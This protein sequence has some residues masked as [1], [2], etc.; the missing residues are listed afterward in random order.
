MRYLIV[1]TSAFGDIIHA[2]SALEFLKQVDPDCQIDWVVEKRMSSLVK[3]HPHVTTCIELDTKK[4]R[5]NIRGSWGE[6]KQVRK[7]LQNEYYD[8]VFDL[9]GNIKS[10][11]VTFLARAEH[12]VG[13]GFKTAPESI[14]ACVYNK[15]YNPPKGQNVRSDYLFLLESYFG[16]KATTSSFTQLITND[17]I[18]QI[19]GNWLI[20]P[21][22]NWINKQ[23]TID[24]LVAFLELCKDAYKPNFV[25]LCGSEQE[26]I[27]A[28]NLVQKFPGS[29]ILYKPSLPTLQHIMSHM[30]LAITMDSLPLHLAAT[31]NLATF[32]FFGPS[33]SQKYNPLGVIHGTFQGPCHYGITFNKRCP[34]LRTCPTGACLRETNP[35]DLFTAFQ[36][37]FSESF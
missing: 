37:W 17:P 11:L 1:K 29:E 12:K 27:Q 10:G 14:S 9:Q 22:S 5:S 26:L 32:S 2:Y 24:T 33:S 20:A 23:L 15:R 36:T 25:F 16:K 30:Q 3:A 18:P 35:Q 13:F 34:K 31:A 19:K 7:A 21:G 8:A 28:Q 4:W 6:M